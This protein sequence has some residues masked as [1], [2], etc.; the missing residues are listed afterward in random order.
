MQLLIILLIPLLLFSTCQPSSSPTELSVTNSEQYPNIVFILADDMG[1]GDPSSYNPES[2]IPTPNIDQIAQN[3]VKF[4]DTH[5]PGP[6]CVPSR[7][8]LIT[9]Q[10]PYRTQLNWRERALIDPSQRTIAELLKDH[11]Y[12]TGMVGKWHLGFDSIDWS[13]IPT[14]QEFRGGPIDHGFDEFFGMHASL[15]I[16][17]YFYIEGN[18]A[19]AAPTDTVADN[20]SEDATTTISGA[21]WRGGDMAPGFSHEE[22]LPKFTERAVSFLEK[23]QSDQPF[24]LY[25]ALTAPHTPWVPTEEFVG[26]TSVGEY[27]DF[28]RQV[29]HTVGQIASTLNSLGLT[30]KT[31]LIFTSDN[32]PVWFAE[33][34]EKFDHRSTASLRGMKIDHWEGGHRI[35]F[36]AQ[37]PREIPAGTVRDDLMG[38]TDVFATLAAVV[39]DTMVAENKD[40]YNMLPAFQNEATEPIR[41][42]MI[43][44][45]RVVRQGSWKFIRDGGEGGLGRSYGYQG[46][47]PAPQVD[48]LYNLAEDLSESNNLAD[49]QPEKVAELKALLPDLQPK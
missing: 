13:D 17:P 5:S 46:Q 20:Q 4:T 21:F 23:Q 22:V 40:S 9:G 8:G 1:Y 47:E 42:E 15:D 31:L 12:R 29:D 49:E 32:G 35:P 30:D 28:T 19:I 14:D 16:P 41:Q 44:G 33:D 45:E 37:W 11:G 48:E 38:F 6:W 34:V 26:T 27:G 39:G 2:K 3:G 18:Q 43:I 7:Y 10:Y 24:F 36:V 25:L